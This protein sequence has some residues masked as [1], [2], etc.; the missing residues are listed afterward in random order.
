[1]WDLHLKQKK[2]CK[3]V[4]VTISAN[5]KFRAKT[6]DKI[7]SL[8]E[9]YPKLLKLGKM[10][11]GVDAY[12]RLG[13]DTSFYLYADCVLLGAKAEDTV[14]NTPQKFYNAASEGIYGLDFEQPV[15]VTRGGSDDIIYRAARTPR[16]VQ[17]EFFKGVS[18]PMTLARS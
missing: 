13:L 5:K 14:Y 8:M 3:P 15:G 9:K 10:W 2:E 4:W 12:K 6:A 16:V 11:K 7:F 1:M 17:N 18:F